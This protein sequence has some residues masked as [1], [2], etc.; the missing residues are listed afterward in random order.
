MRAAR[1]VF[2]RYRLQFPLGRFAGQALL[3]I[4]TSF[5]GESDLGGLLKLG[6][7][8]LLHNPRHPDR[9]LVQL[10]LAGALGQAKRDAEAA[11]LYESV[12]KAGLDLSALDRLRHADVLAR[13]N[14]P[15]PAIDQYKRAL[16]AGLETEQEAWARIQIVQLTRGAKRAD[17]A[18]NG[19]RALHEYPDPLMRRIAAVLQ[20]EAPEPTPAVGAKKR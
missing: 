18:R 6:K 5:P 15:E 14:R 7:Q 1:A 9:A 2:E 12:L 13:L 8:W 16:M 3:G 11:P 19:V 10:K 17:V 4:L 20:T